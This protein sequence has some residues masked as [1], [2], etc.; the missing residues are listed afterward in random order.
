MGVQR[1][2]F[3]II[4]DEIK[5]AKERENVGSI[6]AVNILD[7]ALGKSV[8][9]YFPPFPCMEMELQTTSFYQQNKVGNESVRLFTPGR[10]RT[11]IQGLKNTSSFV[12]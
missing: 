1:P 4:D 12:I 11:D 10:I 6:R 7:V 2:C 9:L 5:R 8:W 3:A